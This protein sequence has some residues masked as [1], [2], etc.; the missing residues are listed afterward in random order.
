[1]AA[2]VG[3]MVYNNDLIFTDVEL[4]R[5]EKATEIQYV[6]VQTSSPAPHQRE[7]ASRL[8][9]SGKKLILQIWWGPESPHSWSRFSMANIAQDAKIRGEFFRE[10]VDP[11]IDSIGPDN[12]YAV[13]MLEETA[14]QF[15]TDSLDPGDPD[16]YSD[17]S[18]GGYS[19]PYY[20]GYSGGGAYGGPWI[21]PLRR[22][23]ADF[24]RFSG[25]DLFES[26]IWTGPEWAAY[27][28][29]VCRRIQALANVR[30]AE[31]IQKKYPGVLATTWDGPDFGGVHC[32][33][34]P[35]MLGAID[36][37]SLN[38]YMSP[39]Q[40]YI[41][42]RTVR[43]L[44]FDKVFQFMSWVGRDNLD[45]NQRRAMLASIYLAGSDIIHL[46]EEPRRAYARDELWTIMQKM[47]GSFSSLPVFRHKPDVFV[48]C[49]QWNVPSYFL[50]N[51]DCAHHE[52]AQGYGLGRYKIVLLDGPEHPGL[53]DWVSSGGIAVAF[54]R[55]PAFIT[56][57]QVSGGK[58]VEEAGFSAT[59]VDYDSG[60]VLLLDRGKTD[61]E[62]AAWQLFVYDQLR[63]LSES[64]GLQAV[65]DKHF[66]PRESGGRYL[67]M[68]SDDGSVTCYLHYSV[69]QAAS[70]V[71]VKGVDVLSGDSDPVL[72]PERSTAIVAHVSLKPWS[73]PPPPD[74]TK[75]A[76]PA[77]PGARRGQPELAELPPVDPLGPARSALAAP[78]PVSVVRKKY[79][80]WDVAGCRYRLALRFNGGDGPVTDQPMI[81]TGRDL[82]ELTGMDDLAWSSVRV[83]NGKKTQTVQVDERDGT[84]F[85][86]AKGNGRLDFDDELVFQVSL[87]RG[88]TA[89]Y[90]LYYDSKPSTAPD[91]AAAPV[92]YEEV[93]T[94]IADAVLSNGRLSVQLKGPAKDPANNTVANY[95]AG[96]ITELSLDGKA[97]TRIRYNWAN[98]FFSN[99]WSSDGGWTKPERIISGPLRTIVR[100]ELPGF[101][102][103]NE[104]GLTT[105]EGK[106]THYYSM[107]GTAPVLDIEQNVSYGRSDRK[108]KAN[109]G[110]YTTPGGAPDAND[111]LIVPVGGSPRVV[112]MH[113]VDVYGSR[114]TEHRPEQGW[115]ALL[116]TAEQH[117]CA[118]F[119][120]R[121][122][123]IRENL[124]RVSYSPAN[125]LTPSVAR[126]PDGYVMS[127][128]YSNKVMQTDDS[129]VRRFRLVGLTDDSGQSVAQQYKIWGE[130][131]TRFGSVEMQAR[132]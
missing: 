24:R 11:I 13:H 72:G 65:F 2:N 55:R 126:R 86:L 19:S 105:L 52:D 42:A 41:Y 130:S 10:V 125:A 14:G 114:Y 32:A 33:D 23:N 116:D 70:P 9:R 101:T 128:E 131:P 82:F 30:F 47:Y 7:V 69:G 99:P 132:E 77:E 46:W 27:R 107:Y 60:T 17:D 31:H 110:F 111:V 121:M 104:A 62:D 57:A 92:T 21:L 88:A 78:K 91:W 3:C 34:T 84:G 75:Y 5:L 61:A 63:G 87:P 119:Y 54:N 64:R 89:T 96:A 118:L 98:Y 79:A 48:I 44:D 83:F 49:G 25:Y 66:S 40:N 93:S 50:K 108:W 1:M 20:T 106:V 22:H 8:A 76:K 18:G 71:Q 29:W 12:I 45:V 58:R 53:K 85:Y 4:R 73:P 35:A 123:E 100:V 15:A 127:L 120:A 56:D 113:D 95:G 74:R 37:F 51:F 36:G 122:P 112:T 26:S 28:Q 59:S 97:F 115:M 16:D 129:V 102:Q 117:G 90:L 68:T 39:L 109:Y 80:D 6:G 38:A 81:L 94:D 124:A 67:E 103:K 43:A